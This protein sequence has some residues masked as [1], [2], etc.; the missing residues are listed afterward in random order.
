MALER[1]TRGEKRTI[2]ERKA[3]LDNP[4]R[5]GICGWLTVL[6]PICTSPSGLHESPIFLPQMR[7]QKERTEGE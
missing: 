4:V 5:C 2:E 7:G 1:I 3:E 6:A